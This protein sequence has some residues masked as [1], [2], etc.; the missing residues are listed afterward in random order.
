MTLRRYIPV[1]GLLA[2]LLAFMVVSCIKTETLP[3]LE[4]VV[5]NESGAKVT[6]AMVALFD[7]QEEWSKM[8]NPV[9]AWRMT[10]ADGKVVFVDLKEIIYYIYVRYDGKDNIID[11]ISTAQPL[12]MN[13]KN[14]IVIHVR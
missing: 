11:E 5:L 9:Q 1:V 13:K 8:K 14:I 10:D 6:G 2:L 12:Q 7:N 4:I 3:Q